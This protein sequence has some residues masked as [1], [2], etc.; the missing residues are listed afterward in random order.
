[1]K[2]GVLGLLPPDWRNI[3][4]QAARRVKEAGF[5]GAQ[6]FIPRPLEADP[7]DIQRVNRA[8]AEGGLEIAQVNGSYERLVDSDDELRAEGVRGLSALIRLGA[9]V[10]TP[11]VYVRPG[12]LS[13]A[14]HWGPHPLN[15]AP[16]TL[17]RL[18]DSLRKV[19]RVAEAE[20]MLLAIEGHVLSPLDT[21]RRARQVIDVVASPALKFNID[22]VNF[23][24]SVSDVH[25]T[26]R[27]L[28]ELFDLLGAQTIA[29]HAKDCTLGDDLVL[30]I[31]EVVLGTGTMDYGLFLRRFQECCPDGYLEIEHLPDDKIPQAR[32]ALVKK[33][34]E[35]GVPLIW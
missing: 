23:M 31:H 1:M 18:V 27:I 25:D 15:T 32:Q 24:G 21:P 14:H 6:W 4:V 17:D 3:D 30:H 16:E 11:S 19:C 35:A 5:L 33:A 2:L 10:Q 28:N 29:G 7:E 9:M 8:F 26:N 13:A 22:P 34:E 12:S 20:G